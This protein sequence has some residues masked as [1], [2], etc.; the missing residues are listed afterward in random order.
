MPAD[1]TT[2]DNVRDFLDLDDDDTEGDDLLERYIRDASR[3][4]RSVTGRKFT[5]TPT[6]P[7]PE[8]PRTVV[9][10]GDRRI[11]VDELFSAADI[12]LVTDVNGV[13]LTGYRYE[14]DSRDPQLGG[15]LVFPKRVD[16]GLLP[17][18]HL[19]NFIRNLDGSEV[20]IP[21]GPITI[22]ATWG[23]TAVPEEIEYL[24]RWAVAVW[25]ENELVEMT[26]FGGTFEDIL[27]PQVLRPLSQYT[28]RMPAVA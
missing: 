12:N 25:N 6:G 1:L 3:A 7:R 28:I 8:G 10:R 22:D 2:L 9:A 19:D 18:D 20:E 5:I 11:Y 26:Q 24:T 4:V 21:S 17:I 16:P 23:Y 13:A 15:T 27:P 14:P